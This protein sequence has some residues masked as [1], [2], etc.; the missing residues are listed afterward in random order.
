LQDEDD[1]VKEDDLEMRR[2]EA[3]GEDVESD[4][5]VLKRFEEDKEK[6]EWCR[7]HE[8]SSLYRNQQIAASDERKRKKVIGVSI[9]A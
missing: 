8:L 1:L 3:S 2:S 6:S 4:E 5:V 7:Q 9:L